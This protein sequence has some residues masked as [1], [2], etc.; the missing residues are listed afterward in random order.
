MSNFVPF[1][2]GSRAHWRSIGNTIIA[3]RHEWST[4]PHLRERQRRRLYY[5]AN[6]YSMEAGA[7]FLISG[8]NP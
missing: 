1:G 7:M 3:W 6:T 8:A 4:S 5:K 2:V